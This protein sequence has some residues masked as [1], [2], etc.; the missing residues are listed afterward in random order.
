MTVTL[1]ESLCGQVPP[2]RRLATKL[3]PQVC[4]LG[5]LQRLLE[6]LLEQLAVRKVSQAVMMGHMGNPRLGPAP[7]RGAVARAL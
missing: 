3:W 5:L 4:R 6:P 2:A 1:L 7:G